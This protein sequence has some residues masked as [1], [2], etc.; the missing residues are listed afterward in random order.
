MALFGGLDFG[1]ATGL[2]YRHDFQQTIRN[3]QAQEQLNRQA[4]IDAENKAKLFAD[5]LETTS[6][7][8]EWDNAQLESYYKDQ[9]KKIGEFVSNNPDFRQNMGLFLKYK[10]MTRGL[11]ENETIQ[12]SMRIKSGFEAMN[13]WDA[14]TKNMNPASRAYLEQK[15]KEYANYTKTG[16]IDGITE[17]GIEF[18]WVAPDEQVNTDKIV[19]EAGRL[20]ATRPT[21]IYIPGFR[22]SFEESVPEE[23]IRSRAASLFNDD[24]YGQYFSK[25]WDQLVA[26]GASKNYGEDPIEWMVTRIEP[27][28]TRKRHNGSAIPQ[29]TGGRGGSGED[30]EGAWDIVKALKAQR[31]FKLPL[32]TSKDIQTLGYADDYSFFG[33][34]ES[35]TVPIQTV[36]PIPKTEYEKEP[37]SIDVGGMIA[38]DGTVIESGKRINGYHSGLAHVF[39]YAKDVTI[40]GVAHRKGELFFAD[41]NDA[42]LD[43]QMR[44]KAVNGYREGLLEK[45]VVELITLSPDENPEDL[46]FEQEGGFFFRDFD[47]ENST[48]EAYLKDKY[49]DLNK[50]Y[51]FES[52]MQQVNQGYKLNNIQERRS[53]LN[54]QFTEKSIEKT[55][56]EVMANY[57]MTYEEAINAVYQQMST[58]AQ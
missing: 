57:D 8:N 43:K 29:K 37:V 28:T 49:K 17:N 2:A 27:N 34:G 33:F 20:L 1:T 5:E 45:Q 48:D 50:Q 46:G 40:D 30:D 19:A 22:G 42:E 44:D 36:L 31:D 14:E 21:N 12:R 58:D 24:E 7:S 26:S 56:S 47:L 23:S 52:V 39:K 32:A 16:S 35:T 25:E 9:F 51:D 11:L 6:L 10:Q 13:K 38:M 55:V 4:K 18:D 15:R 53:W 54:N 41:G 3:R